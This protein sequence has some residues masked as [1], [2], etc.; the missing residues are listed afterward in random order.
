MSDADRTD[1]LIPRLITDPAFEDL[2]EKRY[3]Q[4]FRQKTIASTN[5]IVDS[6][7]W[8]RLVL[9]ACHTEPTIRHAVLALSSLHQLSSLPS[10][11]EANRQHRRYAEKQHQKALEAARSLIASAAPDD[12]DRILTACIIFI[13]FE[14]VRGDYRAAAVHMDSGRA[15]VAQNLRRLQ[16]KG[17]RKDLLEIQQAMARLDIPA[18]CLS[19]RSSPYKYTLSDFHETCPN[20]TPGRFEDVGEAQASLIDLVRWLL[21]IGVC[22]EHEELHGDLPTLARY[23]AEKIKC[24]DLLEKW[25]WHFEE[26]I[27]RAEDRE[28]PAILNMKCWYAA[29]QVLI[30]AEGYGLETRYDRYTYIFEECLRYAKQ[31]SDKLLRGDEKH[32]FSYDFGY[33]IPVYMCAVRCRDPI[34]RRRA[35]GILQSHPR[36]E[37]IWEST[38]AAAVAAQWIAMEEEGLDILTCAADVPEHQRIRHIDTTIDIETHTASLILTSRHALE[39]RAVKATWDPTAVVDGDTCFSRR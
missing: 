23:Q 11:S 26:V 8:D 25:H 22:L 1:G 14:G 2:L 32:S 6:R 9:Q 3:F 29:M 38:A 33:L 5:S 30:K 19:D 13:I 34:L 20:I 24:A 35:L 4:F 17:R 10:D 7:F 15:I 36:Q 37:G 28:S 21:L 31:I 16:Q 27:A 39:G 12:V 18:I